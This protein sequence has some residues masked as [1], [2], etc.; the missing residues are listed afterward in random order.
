MQTFDIKGSKREVGGKKLAK[1]LRR[2]GLIPCVIYG[3]DLKE[4]AF[5]VKNEDLRGLIYTP[6]VYIVNLDI[7]GQACQAVLKDIQFHP[8][9]GNIL[10]I[11]FLQIADNK[12]VTIAI[13][14]TIT[15]HS[16]GVR[17]GGKLQV[18]MRKLNVKGLAANL[19]DTL[20]VD[21]TTLGL[22]QVIKVGALHYDN[23]EILNAKS[24]VVAAVKMTRAAISAEKAAAADAAKSGK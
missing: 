9:S 24:T 2:E 12:P 7:D 5:T 17:A 8:V 1:Q 14:L 20:E 18:E 4:I 21:I 10:H 11:D 15:G 3:G 23:L 22:G 13:P 16:E 19:P 6:N